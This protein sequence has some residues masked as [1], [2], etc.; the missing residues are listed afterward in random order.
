MKLSDY[1]KRKQALID[2][3]GG[4]CVKCGSKKELEFDHIDRKSKK[5]SITT[6]ISYKLSFLLKEVK[7]CQLLCTICHK[8]K[9][10]K[11][12]EA[13]HGTTSRYR[14]HRCRCGDCKKVWNDA[15]KKWRKK[16]KI[17][18]RQIGKV[19]GL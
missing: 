12:K 4:C 11:E 16:R 19:A 2:M 3:W 9:S 6:K 13:K 10:K 18:S 17:R 7:K 15:C 14:H 5:F 1:Y 8:E